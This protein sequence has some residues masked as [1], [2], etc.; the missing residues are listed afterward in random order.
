MSSRSRNLT[1]SPPAEPNDAWVPCQAGDIGRVVRKLKSQKTRHAVS[2]AAMG[3]VACG[4]LVASGLY[5]LPRLATQTPGDF[6][7]IACHEVVSAADEYLAGTLSAAMA[8]RIDTHLL[9][10]AKCTRYIEGLRSERS[11]SAALGHLRTSPKVPQ[12]S[13]PLTDLV[14]A[15]VD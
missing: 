8:A 11:S 4:L 14:L 9:S 10:C 12:F 2:Q 7:G 3:V 15:A 5:A 1:N 6:G 13:N